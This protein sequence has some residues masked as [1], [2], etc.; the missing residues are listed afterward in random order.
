MKLFLCFVQVLFY[1]LI[2]KCYENIIEKIV[3]SLID[4]CSSEINTYIHTQGN[5]MIKNAVFSI[6]LKCSEKHK[7]RHYCKVLLFKS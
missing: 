6:D 2:Q 1:F 7:K 5:I 3:I 4:L